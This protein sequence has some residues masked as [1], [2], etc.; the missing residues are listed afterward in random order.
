MVCQKCKNSLPDDARFCS[1]CGTPVSV[2]TSTAN[3][4]VTKT[5]NSD[6]GRMDLLKEYIPPEL[7]SKIMQAGRKVKGVRLR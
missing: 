1:H 7:A 2:S 5:M 4:T 3:P 6:D